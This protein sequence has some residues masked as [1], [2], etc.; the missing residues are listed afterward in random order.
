MC[1]GVSSAPPLDMAQQLL[2]NPV[3]ANAAL[4]YGQGIMNVGQRYID[5]EVRERRLCIDNLL[6]DVCTGCK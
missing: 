4:Q 1:S 3:V 6:C 2:N 5:Q